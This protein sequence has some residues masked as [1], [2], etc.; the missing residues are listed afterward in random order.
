MATLEASNVVYE[1]LRGT[2]GRI[3]ALPVTGEPDHHFNATFV[4]YARKYDVRMF[5]GHSSLYTPVVREV[6]E[7]LTPLSTAGELSEEN[8]RWLRNNEYS[9]VLAHDTLFEPRIAPAVLARLLANRYLSFDRKSAGVYKLTVLKQPRFSEE[10][11]RREFER[12]SMELMPV[13]VPVVFISGWYDREAPPNS[14]PYRWMHEANSR[15]LVRRGTSQIEL[16]F[17]ALCPYG[18]L[19]ISVDGEPGNATFRHVEGGWKEYTVRIQSGIGYV[20]IDFEAAR[21]FTVAHDSRRFGC[22]VSDVEATAS[23]STGN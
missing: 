13:D 19:G 22:M 11:S 5:N 10:Q 17:S 23:R 8:W 4:Y 16:R 7:R 3:L 18:N 9:H 20:P 1:S 6:W 21:V 12:L 14:R 2:P 15:L